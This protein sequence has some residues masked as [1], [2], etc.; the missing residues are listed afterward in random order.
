[1]VFVLTR[2]T[3]KLSELQIFVYL[4]NF[5]RSSTS[6]L[7]GY[8]MPPFRVGCFLPILQTRN[9]QQSYCQ[10]ANSNVTLAPEDIVY[11][12][13]DDEWIVGGYNRLGMDL[14]FS[15]ISG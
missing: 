4:T 12:L 1:M 5:Y 13:V 11:T 15:V 3:T 14:Q 9:S 8:T 2:S 6:P 7:T 10:L